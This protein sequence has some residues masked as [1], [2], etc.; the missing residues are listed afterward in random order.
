MR[1]CEAGQ[2]PLW[3]ASFLP[4]GLR[5]LT[6]IPLTDVTLFF[7][8]Q[9]LQGPAPYAANPLS[10]MTEDFVHE[11]MSG[12]FPIEQADNY[13]DWAPPAIHLSPYLLHTQLFKPCE[14]Q[15]SKASQFQKCIWLKFQ[16]YQKRRHFFDIRM[17]CQQVK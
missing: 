10:P 8:L 9:P 2:P 15:S 4:F 14:P 16:V 3:R 12:Q 5:Q 6:H 7:F 13:A 11:V 1:D 17:F